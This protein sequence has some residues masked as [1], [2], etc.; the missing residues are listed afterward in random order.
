[1]DQ[2]TGTRSRDVG[3]EDGSAARMTEHGPA[4][5]DDLDQ[6]PGAARD[7]GAVD[8]CERE[9][10]RA[11][12]VAVRSPRLGFGEPDMGDLGVGEDHPRDHPI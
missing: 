1:V 3:A 5:G 8:G 6:A 2:L 12:A 9:R 11:H 7:H 10:D 4:T